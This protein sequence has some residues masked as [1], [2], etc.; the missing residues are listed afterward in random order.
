MSEVVSWLGGMRSDVS[1]EVIEPALDRRVI[2]IKLEFV[3]G[4]KSHPVQDADTVPPA[5]SC[6]VTMCVLAKC[7]RCRGLA[8]L[9]WDS[10][11]RRLVIL[12][13]RSGATHSSGVCRY[14]E[15]V[16]PPFRVYICVVCACVSMCCFWARRLPSLSRC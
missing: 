2:S 12:L 13:A 11:V 6:L 15:R 16:F 5:M 4:M 9:W 10:G 7:A 8:Q 3:H 1:F 14:L